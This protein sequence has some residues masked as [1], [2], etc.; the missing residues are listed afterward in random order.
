M[1]SWS[2]VVLIKGAGDLGT[3]VAH[4]LHRVGMRVVVTELPQPLVIRRPVAFANAVYEG[5]VTVEGVTARRVA[6][7]E[8]EIATTWGRGEVP[9]V[10]DPAGLAVQVLRPDVVVDAILAKRNTGTRITDAPAVIALGPGFTAGVDCHAVVETERGHYLGRVIWEGA[11][12]PNTGVPGEVGG[13]TAR[14]VLRA[15][16]GGLLQGVGRIG[17]VVREGETVA[18]VAGQPIQSPFAGVLRGLL[19]D[20]VPVRAGMKVGDVDPRGKPEY[21]FTISD[22]ARAVGGGVLEAILTLLPASGAAERLR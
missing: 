21:C 9:V 22:K 6:L 3:G 17:D 18:L 15:P 8:G 13:Q 1:K 2:F 10:V 11:A 12:R 7:D 4:R 14:R 16:A 19:H 5:A 20:G